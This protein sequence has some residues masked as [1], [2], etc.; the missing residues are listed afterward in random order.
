MDRRSA[1]PAL[2]A[3]TFGQFSLIVEVMLLDPGM[4]ELPVQEP[5]LLLTTCW[6]S[7]WSPSTTVVRVAVGVW[8]EQQNES[9]DDQ[10][11]AKPVE[12]RQE[13]DQ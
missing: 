13:Q 11:D 8:D 1:L 6:H 12:G 7:G 3:T 4:S 5:A 10:D 2:L 9:D